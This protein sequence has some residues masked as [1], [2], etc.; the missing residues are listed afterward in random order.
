M[1]DETPKAEKPKPTPPAKPAGG[2]AKP[3]PTKKEAVQVI[4]E[5]TGDPL[6]E[7]L[8][9]K[10]PGAIKE[11]QLI[12]NQQVIRVTLESTYQVL[13]FLKNEAEP[14]FNFLMDLTAVHFPDRGFEVIYQLY[15]LDEAR[16]FR[17]KT[18]VT[19]QD[20]VPSVVDLWSTANWLEREVFDLFGIRFANH[21][22]LRRILLPEG[23]EGHPLRKDYPLEYQDNQWVADH[24][25]I[26][27][28][29]VDAD[30]TGKFE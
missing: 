23:W 30:L 7:T 11:A 13:C 22:D 16:R 20:S 3:T 26:L 9:A 6:V 1:S 8:K 15:A 18:D 25:N 27:E 5:L 2:A 29:P 19:E 24:L 10:F 28:L 4:F 12:H 14:D 17:V 21:P